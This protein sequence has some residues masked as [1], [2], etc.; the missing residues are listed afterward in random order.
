MCTDTRRQNRSLLAMGITLVAV[1]GVSIFLLSYSPSVVQAATP[2][3]GTWCGMTSDGG[4]IRAD[5]SQDGRWLLD[6]AIRTS[7]GT[8]S[9]SET[10]NGKTQIVTSKFIYRSGSSASR[11]GSRGRC[12]KPPCRSTVAP[13]SNATIRGT[14][15]SV[16]SLRGT[17][18][19]TTTTTDSSGRTRSTRRYTGSYVAWPASVAPCP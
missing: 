5:V 2:M 11:V 16:D 6:I 13:S 12:T 9:S 8:V 15:R 7:K 4:S 19:A 3:G 1:I 10:R 18:T 14:F 17:Y